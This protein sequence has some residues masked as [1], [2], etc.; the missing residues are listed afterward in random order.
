MTDSA[1]RIV[2]L[3]PAATEWIFALG[4]GDQLVGVSHECD[5]P[6][7]ASTLAR[8][9]SSRIDGT[10]SSR[11]IDE[12]VRDHL[13]TQTALYTLDEARL[14]ELRP[15]VI[16][17]Q[18]LCNVCAV[19]RHAVV[20][21]IAGRDCEVVD[22]HAVTFD[23]VFED[24]EAICQA[25]A[26]TAKSRDS[27]RALRE[28]SQQIRESANQRQD[29]P[30]QRSKRQDTR[31]TVTLLEWTDPL[32]CSGHWTPQLIEWAGGTDPIGVSGEPSRQI[33]FEVLRQTDPDMLLVACC[34][35]DLDRSKAEWNKLRR[36]PGWQDLRCVRTNQVI[37]FDGS[38]YFN[39]AGPRLVE[40]LDEVAKLI[41]RWSDENL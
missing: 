36:D 20:R 22:L 2:S 34:G 1:K 26:S 32:F 16:V 21:A 8:V 24:A 19:D 40:S 9:T 15:D 18:S 17:T 7:K 25:A 4:L 27:L 13:E 41:R 3:L 6:A 11:Q 30:S 12:Q 23:Q 10:Q 38:A 33:S 39:R 31:P 28:R 5:F 35:L 37:P 29:I 14:A